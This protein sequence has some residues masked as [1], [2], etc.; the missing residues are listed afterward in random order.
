MPPKRK[1]DEVLA[2]K[3]KKT[4]TTKTVVK[5][6]VEE[7]QSVKNKAKKQQVPLKSTKAV[8]RCYPKP[9]LPPASGNPRGAYAPM[10]VP[11]SAA[12]VIPHCAQPFSSFPSAPPS[13][14]SAIAFADG[15]RKAGV[16][17]GKHVWLIYHK[18][19][20]QVFLVAY[21]T[22]V[23]RRLTPTGFFFNSHI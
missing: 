9:G 7:G 23:E 11:S 22:F 14:S 12:F 13:S 15:P 17:G 1:A 2:V 5:T 16:E 21:E 3:G 19:G 8:V 10:V 4:T 18:T 20:R 6:V